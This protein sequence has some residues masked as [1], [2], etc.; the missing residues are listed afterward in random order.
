[1]IQ[2]L[3][4]PVPGYT[5][6][7]AG[8]DGTIVH[9]GTGR[10]LAQSCHSASG[11]W[12]VHVP[13]IGKRKVHQLVAAAFL[14][15]RPEGLETRHSDGVKSHNGI[16]NLCYGTRKD[17]AQD[18][19]R[20][21]SLP[22]TH[23]TECP[24]GHPY[25]PENTYTYDGGRRCRRCTYEQIKEREKESRRIAKQNGQ[26]LS[27]AQKRARVD[28]FLAA[29]P[30]VTDRIIAEATGVSISTVRRWRLSKEG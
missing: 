13:E 8:M 4:R 18:C 11:Y 15:Q 25:T 1:M 5:D 20:H 27:A 12:R 9:G 28:R 7:Y 14:G 6:L 24:Q 26:G 19:V 10:P 23:K 30:P 2:T 22:N 17:N 29:E 3:Y 16:G 21:G